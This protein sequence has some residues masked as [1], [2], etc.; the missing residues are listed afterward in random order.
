MAYTAIDDPEAYFQTQLYTGNGS[1]NHAITLGADTDMQ[2][3]LV[4]IKNRDAADSH[5]I[6]DALR[7]ATKFI[8]SDAAD[9]ES[10]DADTLD[11]FTSDGF[12]VDADDKVNTS[13]EDYV[14][15]NWKANG[16]GSANTAGS[17]NT[18]ATSANTTSKFSII[19]YE[20]DGT[21][22]ATIGHG[23][24][25]APTFI[26]LHHRDMT[27][28]AAENWRVYH[29]KNT[30]APATDYLA[31]NT[32]AATADDSNAWNDTVPSSTLITLGN[33][34]ASNTD[35][36][37]FVAYAWRDVQGFS[38]FGSYKGNGNADGT[39]VFTGFR[40]AFLLIKSS[41]N[42]GTAWQMWDNKRAVPFNPIKTWD[43]AANNTT[44]EDS[45][46][47]G[48]VDFLS[49]GFKMRKVGNDNNGSGLTY[50]YAAFAESPLVNSNGV[51]CNGR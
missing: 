20:G 11:S 21:S 48:V 35:D 42:S 10:T 25:A 16:T 41:S 14:S 22:G 31:L 37:N 6:F 15:W 32:T 36:K 47:A 43:L 9:A 1:A 27:G 29:D 40:P 8:S 12:Q 34:G 19:T 18:T 49:N 26:L 44:A 50:I 28:G 5:C 45:I 2:P 3:D 24:G 38:K 23:I 17:I 4:W 30:S 13:S 7:G 39:F 51:P 46:A 33:G